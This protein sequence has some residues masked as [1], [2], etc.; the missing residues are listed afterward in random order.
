VHILPYWE[1]R[2][3]ALG[4]AVDHVLGTYAQVQSALAPLPVVIGETGWPAAG[5]MRA[6]ARPG[7]AEQTRFL[8][9]L[10][11]R[12]QGLPL[13]VIEAYDQPWKASLEGVAGAAWGVFRADGSA[14]Y[15]PL[16]PPADDAQAA[17]LAALAG[18]LALLLLV[19]ARGRPPALRWRAGVALLNGALLGLLAWL[20]LRE[21]LMLAPLSWPWASRAALLLASMA[22]AAM[23][24]MALA[25]AMAGIQRDTKLLQRIRLGGLLATIAGALWLLADG[26]YLDLAWPA[27]AAPLVPLLVQRLFAAPAPQPLAPALSVLLAG[28]AIGLAVSEGASNHDALALAGLMLMLA[29]GSVGFRSVRGT[30]AERA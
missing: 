10:L 12:A 4:G 27:L 7:T 26:R 19:L 28:C 5:R 9:E 30:V 8:R 14:R 6:G 15:R 11:L 1:D 18:A 23:E 25:D 24:A 20:P 29:A 3:V 21:L 13:N 2:P 17:A 22:W 16:G